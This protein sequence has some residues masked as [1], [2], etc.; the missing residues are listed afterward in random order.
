[1]NHSSYIRRNEGPCFI[2]NN[3]RKIL[4]SL[5]INLA[6]DVSFD[7][8][9]S[10][11]NKS[12]IAQKKADTQYHSEKVLIHLPKKKTHNQIGINSN[13]SI[14]SNGNKAPNQKR[15]LKIDSGVI[16]ECFN[17]KEET[18]RTAHLL[19]N[20]SNTS[21]QS[22]SDRKLFYMANA[23]IPTDHSL[24]DFIQ[25]RNALRQNGNL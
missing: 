23:C 12:A 19:L 9:S 11:G 3:K 8:N 16:N 4:S 5:C 18:K 17:N 15:P 6:D 24:E 20:E 21:L 10:I 7:T 14:K 13:S 1:M 25:K 2:S 22:I